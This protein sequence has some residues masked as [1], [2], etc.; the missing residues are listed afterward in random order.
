MFLVFQKKTLLGVVCAVTMFVLLLGFLL[1]ETVSTVGLNQQ[2][3][4][5]DPGHG[6]MDGG[7]VGVDGILEKDLNLQIAKKLE[8]KLTANGYRVIMTR[9]EDISLH[10]EEKNTVREQKNADLKKR[11]SIA[12]EQKAGLFVSIHM[13]K[14]EA[15]DVKGA[16]VFYKKEDPTGEQYAKNIMAELK[17]TDPEN[18]RQQKVLPNKNLTFSKLNVPAVLVECGFISNQDE[19]AKLCEETYQQLLVD[20]I[21]NGIVMT[22]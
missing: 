21:F 17:K 8:Q 7:G 22:P 18:H 9:S 4:V 16:Q 11:A 1:P 5:I 6:G 12:N 19:A 20:A 13:N 3:I 14:F 10:D 15:S 2:L